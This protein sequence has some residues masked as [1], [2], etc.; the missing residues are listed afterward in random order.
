MQLETL[1]KNLRHHVHFLAHDIGERNIWHPAALHATQDYLEQT[2]LN[3]NYA[4]EKQTYMEQ[5]VQ[6]ANLEITHKGDSHAEQSILIGAHYDTV[7][8]SP[9]A[10]D[11]A[12]GVAVLLELSRLFNSLPTEITIRFVAFVNEEAPFFFLS[13]QGSRIYAKAARQHGDDI[14]LMIA[15]ETMGYY[16]TDP[17]SQKYPPL[18]RFFYPNR[19]DFISLVSNFRSRRIM[20]KLAQAFRDST[21]FP[22]EHVATFGFI[23][24]VAWSDHLSF[25]MQ[26]Y[27][28]L[29]V[30]D[31]AFYR[32]P[33]YHSATDTTDKLDYVRLA[34]VCDG[35][36]KAVNILAND[37]NL[38]QGTSD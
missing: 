4:V 15:L 32:Y 23:P 12:S 2:W 31:T 30:T 9:G 34:Q 5:D 13:S 11:N 16:R 37:P 28:A 27:K 3:Q 36:F 20:R 8:G 18:F 7:R 10:N 19:A 17:Y 14:Q 21:D 29:M 38:S 25:W 33:H 26:G 24:G 1:E 22:L 6:C 35:L